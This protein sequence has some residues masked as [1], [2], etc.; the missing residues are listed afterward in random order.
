MSIC[1][2]FNNIYTLQKY[3]FFFNNKKNVSFFTEFAMV[4]VS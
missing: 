2:I 1:R 3:L 4:V